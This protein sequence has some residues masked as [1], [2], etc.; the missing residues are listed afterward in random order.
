MVQSWCCDYLNNALTIRLKTKLSDDGELYLSAEREHHLLIS[1]HAVTSLLLGQTDSCCKSNFNKVCRLWYNCMWLLPRCG[2]VSKADNIAARAARPRSIVKGAA[3][4]SPIKNW[5]EIL[6]QSTAL[7]TTH[8]VPN[9]IFCTTFNEI[10]S[11]IGRKV[12]NISN[13]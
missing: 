10:T 4:I 8:D 12:V 11:K 13:S 9:F 5:C 1:D 6:K 7:F 2:G 3:Y